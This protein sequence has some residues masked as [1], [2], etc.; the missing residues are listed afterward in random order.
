MV[1]LCRKV[2]YQKWDFGMW[3]SHKVMNS[4]SKVYQLN[5]AV[6]QLRKYEH[7][8]SH[9]SLLLLFFLNS[10]INCSTIECQSV[11]LKQTV[12]PMPCV[13]LKVSE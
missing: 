8:K 11:F 4:M 5:D 13:Y 1:K 6:Y 12:L 2:D 10:A 7:N 3:L 9:G